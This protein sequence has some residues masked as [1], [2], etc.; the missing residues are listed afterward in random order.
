MFGTL[1]ASGF[2]IRHAKGITFDNVEARFE[3][4]D[5]RP[6]FVV[7][8]VAD[9]DFHHVRADKVAGTPTFVLDSVDD[10][11]TSTGRPVPDHDGL[12]ESQ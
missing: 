9:A 6:V 10:F 1:P 4:P 11:R 5:T 12:P 7:R 8:E 2:F 3:N